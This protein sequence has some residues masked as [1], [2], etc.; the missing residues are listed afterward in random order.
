MPFLLKY[1][2]C[3][4]LDS[5]DWGGLPLDTEVPNED[6]VGTISR[7]RTIITSFMMFVED[8]LGITSY[9]KYHA[10]MSRHYQTCKSCFDVLQTV[11]RAM[12][13]ERRMMHQRL[14]KCIVKSDTSCTN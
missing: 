13:L 10:L 1:Q 6:N 11:P 5:V 12:S 3:L 7:F 2:F 4:P 9:L 8:S 14:C